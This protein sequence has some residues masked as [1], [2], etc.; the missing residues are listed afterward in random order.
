MFSVVSPERFAATG[1]LE[2]KRKTKRGVM[3]VTQPCELPFD[4][5]RRRFMASGA[6]YSRLNFATCL[7]RFCD[8]TYRSTI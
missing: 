6:F 1:A 3:G 7:T 2:E 5:H 4:G 8:D